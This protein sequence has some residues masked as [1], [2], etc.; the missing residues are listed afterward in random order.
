MASSTKRYLKEV[1]EVIEKEGCR[2]VSIEQG[3]HY[4]IRYQTPRGNVHLL[5]VSRSP[6]KAHAA[7][8][9]RRFIRRAL[10][11]EAT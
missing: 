6:S 11:A 4:K 5:V 8:E 1:K 9:N 10:W 7:Q 2:I 3:K